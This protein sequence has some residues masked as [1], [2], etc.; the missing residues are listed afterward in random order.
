MQDKQLPT[1]Y[2]KTR[3]NE[4]RRLVILVILALVVIGTSLIGLIWGASA[5]LFGGLCLLG[6]AALIGGLWLLLGLIQKFVG[7]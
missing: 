2:R 3:R 5:A 6:G 1:N 4:E 7:E